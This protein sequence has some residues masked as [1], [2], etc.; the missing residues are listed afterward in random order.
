MISCACFAH[1]DRA[2]EFLYDY[3]L[4][5][6]KLLT[7]L[8]LLGLPVAVVAAVRARR[9]SRGLQLEVE[10][11][12]DHQAD[13]RLALE[14]AILPRAALKR[15]LKAR[16]AAERHVNV[17]RRRPARL[18]RRV[19]WRSRAT[20]VRRCAPKSARSAA[21]D[22][23]RRSHRG[24]QSGGG[25]IHG[26][27]LAASQLR[28]VRERGI[29]LRVVVDRLAASGGYLMACAA[30]EVIAAP[31][32][33]IGSIGVVAQIPNFHRLLK[34]HDI[35]FE[36]ITAGEFKRTLSLFGENTDRGRAKF[37]AEIDD[38][39]ALFKAFI[40][41]L[42]PQV[43][44]ERVATGEWWFGSRAVEL[45]WSIVSP[46]ATMSLLRPARNARSAVRAR[47]RQPLL[48]RL[49][50]QGLALARG[51]YPALA[52]SRHF[53]PCS[54]VSVSRGAAYRVEV[55][56]D[57]LRGIVGVTAA[58]HD[59][60]R[61]P[62]ARGCATDQGI[63]RRDGIL[64]QGQASET[65]ADIDVGAGEI[66]HEVWARTGE[67]VVEAATEQVEIFRGTGAVR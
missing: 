61:G 5:A 30:D 28:R 2:M 29:R 45:G 7:V 52:L 56:V 19:P 49:F 59:R 42:R 54:A 50:D 60:Q 44:V 31:F 9:A 27:S 67:H 37:Q 46:P 34:R 14:M 22:T 32:A 18:R 64:V 63:A 55:D 20:A 25:T 35:D 8:G 10:R 62:G 39:H 6:A 26:Y 40:A 12:N 53:A 41:E 57:D 23:G 24:A 36:Q 58:H 1:G 48:T 65:I 43:D 38:A 4:F 21:R 17:A 3:L 47:R 11:I 33:I 51:H 16:R 15:Q 66:E 13:A